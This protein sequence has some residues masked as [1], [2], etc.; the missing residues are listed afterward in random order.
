MGHPGHG[1]P[2]GRASVPVHP[3]PCKD[4]RGEQRCN[5]EEVPAVSLQQLAV[6]VR[7]P[8]ELTPHRA[9]DGARHAQRGRWV[10]REVLQA[11][12]LETC[13]GDGVMCLAQAR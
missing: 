13:G 10:H 8:K 1:P 9:A 5:E 4:S 7:P 2:F 6:G 3:S 12:C 11:V